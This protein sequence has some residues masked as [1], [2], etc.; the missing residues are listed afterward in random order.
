MRKDSREDIS[1]TITS[2]FW[3]CSSVSYSCHIKCYI[4]FICLCMWSSSV[5]HFV[6][7]PRVLLVRV[8]WTLLHK[9]CCEGHTAVQEVNNNEQ[10]AASGHYCGKTT[11]SHPISTHS[12]W[13]QTT[14]SSSP[15]SRTHINAV[16]HLTFNRSW[17]SWLRSKSMILC[18]HCACASRQRPCFLDMK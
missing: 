3:K 10:P 8:S 15:K 7:F 9:T 12:Q 6:L 17:S 1:R 2:H 16:M 5:P 4:P 13:E 11:L 14:S 18:F